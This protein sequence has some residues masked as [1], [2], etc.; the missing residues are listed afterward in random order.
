MAVSRLM[1]SRGVV[2][3]ALSSQ[4][5]L[6]RHEAVA[7]A[8]AEGRHSRDFFQKQPETQANK[9]FDSAADGSVSGKG[10]RSVG[11]V[12]CDVE[13]PENAGKICRLL[14]NFGPQGS[15]Y[16]HVLTEYGESK[17]TCG[18]KAM[19]NQG[20]F[21]TLARGT[22]KKVHHEAET[23]AEFC[24][25]L[26][27]VG[28]DRPPLVVVETAAG[29]RSIFDSQLP[30]SCEILVGGETKGVNKDVLDCL[31]PGFDMIVFVPMDGFC[32]SMNVSTAA[33]VVLYE[34][35]RQMADRDR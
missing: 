5:G 19:V 9:F 18:P 8:H 26:K 12:T 29:A 14:A 7:L 16:R 6:R 27:A 1:T 3:A 17:C 25:R 23:V 22:H 20:R 10:D 21:K 4:K 15:V 32:K 30:E 2:S 33:G 11:V 28:T 31:V 24:A 13:H 34:Y 35:A